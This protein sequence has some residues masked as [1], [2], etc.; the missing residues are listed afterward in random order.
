M[1]HAG[2]GKDDDL[3]SIEDGELEDATRF[4]PFMVFDNDETSKEEKEKEQVCK[5]N[6]MDGYLRVF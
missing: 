1:L 2:G 5:K 3:E 4:C 6:L